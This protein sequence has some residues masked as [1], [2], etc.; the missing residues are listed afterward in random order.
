MC[1]IAGIVGSNSNE[2]F[3]SVQKMT[4]LITHRGPDSVNI[5]R[6]S[7]AILGHT[8]LSVIDLSRKAQ[9]P[10]ESKDGRYS[11]VF[12]GEIYNFKYLKNQLSADY[13]FATQSDSEV[14]LASFIK[15]GD[16][17]LEYLDGM[18]AFSIWDKKEKTL[19]LARD[20]F[21]KK[22]LIYS[23]KNNTF[24]FASDIMSLKQLQD[25]GDVSKE[26]IKSLFRFRCIY[27][28]LTIFENFRKL[29]PGSFLI[30]NR[31]GVKVSKYYDL[32]KKSQ[33]AL[34]NKDTVEKDI[35][36]LILKSVDKRLDVDV[37][38]GVFL[39]PSILLLV[40][41]FFPI[42]HLNLNSSN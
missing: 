13:D 15:W 9:Q 26:A 27:E 7:N 28:P 20:R 42:Q 14:L 30:Y 32:S 4:S 5:R 6:Y 1:G 37:P 35:T 17:C 22:P 41:P 36:D 10:M 40:E 3:S 24:S 11:L 39:S 23:S 33:G 34:Y 16:K 31:Y 2:D 25:G 18:F 21:G 38:L 19:F 8:R 29:P 12:N